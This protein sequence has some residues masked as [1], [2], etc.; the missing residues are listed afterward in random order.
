M[1]GHLCTEHCMDRNKKLNQE[2][3]F[4]VRGS[5]G[6]GSFE[7]EERK[8]TRL[9]SSIQISLMSWLERGFRL[10]VEGGD[11]QEEGIMCKQAV[12]GAEA[13]VPEPVFSS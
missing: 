9:L 12:V 2:N 5:Q 4:C 7:L 10:Q 8:I 6:S 13:F 11:Q 1:E 3:N